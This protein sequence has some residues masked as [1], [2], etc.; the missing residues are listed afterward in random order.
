MKNKKILKKQIWELEK[1]DAKFKLYRVQKKGGSNLQSSK[2]Q[3]V[4]KLMNLRIDSL[5]MKYFM[6]SLSQA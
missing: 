4:W 1:E 3:V 2:S 5:P 6:H